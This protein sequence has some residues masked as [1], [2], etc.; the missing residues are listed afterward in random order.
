MMQEKNVQSPPQ[1]P[2]ISTTPSALLHLSF[3]KYPKNIEVLLKKFVCYYKKVRHFD[4]K[5]VLVFFKTTFMNF[6]LCPPDVSPTSH[7]KK[8]TLSY[9]LV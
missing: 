4:K 9:N 3:L 5:A 1:R 2:K 6:Y 7:P 8:Y